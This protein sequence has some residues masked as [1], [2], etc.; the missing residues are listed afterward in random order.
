MAADTTV[1]TLYRLKGVA[2]TIEAMFEALDHEQL[3]ALDARVDIPN[4]LGVPAIVID[5]V[6]VKAEASWCEDLR[7]TTGCPVSRPSCRAA[8]LLVFAVD[9]EVYAIGY[10]QGYR[11]IP[12]R[13]KDRRFGLCFAIRR[14]DPNEVKDLVRQTPG[15]GKT[16]ITLVPGGASVHA[17]G[18]E[19]HAQVVRHIGG[20]LSDVRLTVSSRSRARVSSA[21]GGVGLR[22]HLG[23]EGTNLIADVREIARVCREES[24]RKELEFVERVIPV[25][26]AGLADRLDGI[27]DDLLGQPD[28]GRVAVVVPDDH[29]DDYLEARACQ[30]RINS[31]Q[32][33]RGEEFNLSYLLDRLRVQ[34][35]GHRVGALRDGDVT[36]FKDSRA[37]ED[38][39]LRR[40]K[41]IQWAEVDITLGERR[42]FLLNGEWHEIGPAYLASV[43]AAVERLIVAPLSTDL[44]AWDLAHNERRF[45][46]D[47]AEHCPGY[48]CV[49]GKLAR[50]RLHRGNGVEVCDLLLPDDTLLMA[51]HAHKDAGPLSHLFKQALV[52]V[53]ALQHDP[54][55]MAEFREKVAKAPGGRLLPADFQP[56]KVIL[57]IL[58]KNGSEL[59]ADTLFPFAQVS[60]VHTATTLRSWGVTVEVVGIRGKACDCE[61]DTEAV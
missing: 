55:T 56:T 5:A 28:E 10:D 15:A 7:R 60:L 2:P 59:T 54:E 61:A 30:I 25:K 24:P 41:A 16:D 47:V 44:P 38:D 31:R 12:D 4:G 17:F 35:A 42:F 48:V 40:F 6:Y 45:C 52:A 13:L 32:G 22:L 51:K 23:V 33:R 36:L 46:Q 37:R 18:I 57:A 1:R 50:T 29:W 9:H 53:Q 21:Q 34:R 20:R 43:R 14:V 19:E 49:D 3:D 11:L 27:F 58:L 39:V 8:G 26:D